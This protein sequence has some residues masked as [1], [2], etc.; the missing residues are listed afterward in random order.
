MAKEDDYPWR[1]GLFTVVRKVLVNSDLIQL[2]EKVVH[3]SRVLTAPLFDMLWRQML[4]TLVVMGEGAAAKK[5]TSYYLY[6]NG[7]GMYEAHWRG[8]P[9]CLQPGSYVGSQPQDIRNFGT[10]VFSLRS[11]NCTIF[12]V[13]ELL[14][15]SRSMSDSPHWDLELA[16]GVQQCPLSCGAR[17]SLRSCSRGPAVPTNIWPSRLRAGSAHV[18]ENVRMDAR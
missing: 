5:L 12:S 13:S 14:P 10:R 8:A 17:G 2:L 6:E 15:G 18:T 3:G 9:D 4:A 1:S 16:V 11:G 7:D